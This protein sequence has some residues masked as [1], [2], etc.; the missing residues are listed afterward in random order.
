MG[1]AAALFRAVRVV[2]RA[3]PKLEAALPASTA[4]QLAAL[5]VVPP[6]T[7]VPTTMLQNL[8]GTVRARRGAPPLHEKGRWGPG[9]PTVEAMG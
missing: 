8:W 3:V 4:K 1:Q 5:V 7:P 9:A 6:D 2:R